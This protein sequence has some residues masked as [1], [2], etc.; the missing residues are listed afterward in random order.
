MKQI[1]L[2]HRISNHRI[3][4]S[5]SRLPKYTWMVLASVAARALVLAG[6]SPIKMT[7][8]LSALFIRGIKEWKGYLSFLAF[9]VYGF[10]FRILRHQPHQKFTPRDATD[11]HTPALGSRA[12]RV[13]NGIRRIL[14]WA[15]PV[16]PTPRRCIFVMI[17]NKYR[18]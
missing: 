5:N 2:L 8:L 12:K 14:V 3:S 11:W 15:Y 10:G 13:F 1:I 7:C 17:Y 6:L 9:R 18:I 4:I 16:H